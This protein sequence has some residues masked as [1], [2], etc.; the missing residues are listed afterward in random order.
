MKGS[1]GSGYQL[2]I[3]P[4]DRDDPDRSLV[5]SVRVVVDG[6]EGGAVGGLAADEPFGAAV[7]YLSLG[8]AVLDRLLDIATFRA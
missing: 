5:V 6:L 7:V 1:A 3:E 2:G 8:M 4:P